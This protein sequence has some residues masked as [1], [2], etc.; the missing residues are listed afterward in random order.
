MNIGPWGCWP[1][2]VTALERPKPPKSKT[3]YE[4][5][6]VCVTRCGTLS[7][8]SSECWKP[9]EAVSTLGG[10][11]L[12]KIPSRG[13]AEAVIFSLE[14]EGNVIESDHV[15]MDS[16]S[17]INVAHQNFAPKYEHVQRTSTQQMA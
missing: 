8:R 4:N 10:D 16:V 13:S 12:I 9:K 11:R 7:H 14:P 15:L 6:M 1:S 2:E 3:I 5:V 17:C